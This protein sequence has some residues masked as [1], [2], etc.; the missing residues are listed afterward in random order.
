MALPAVSQQS[1]L[2]LL[3]GA[4]LSLAV[5]VAA[6]GNFSIHLSEMVRQIEEKEISNGFCWGKGLGPQGDWRTMFGKVAGCLLNKAEI[7]AMKFHVPTVDSR[8]VEEHLYMTI[9]TDLAACCASTSKKGWCIEEVSDAYTHL[10]EIAQ[11]ASSANAAT[12]DPSTIDPDRIAW[13][14]ASLT[15]AANHLLGEIKEGYSEKA[16]LLLGTCP[17]GPNTCKSSDLT[18]LSE[19]LLAL[20]ASEPRR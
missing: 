4:A 15:L 7:V 14:Y 8:G 5:P 12:F 18:R 2:L 3:L 20:K 19:Q 13:A 1:S 10:A 11:A 17:G 6:A 9:C 16:A